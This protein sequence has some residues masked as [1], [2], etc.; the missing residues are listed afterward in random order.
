MFIVLVT[1]VCFKHNLI[2]FIEIQD[3]QQDLG[4]GFVKTASDGLS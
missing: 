4:C 2:K 3:D 1:P